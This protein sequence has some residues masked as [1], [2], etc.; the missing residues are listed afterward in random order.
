MDS[1]QVV[2]FGTSTGSC[3]LPPIALSR[4][5]ADE[6][7]ELSQ[8][9]AQAE[10]GIVV[11][12]VEMPDQ[13]FT[14]SFSGLYALVGLAEYYRTENQTEQANSVLNAV[15]QNIDALARPSLKVI[16]LAGVVGVF[17]SLNE[18]DRAQEVLAQATGFAEAAENTDQR[19]ISA[20]ALVQ[21]YSALGDYAAAS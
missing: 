20:M 21:A 12:G 17:A 2:W 11:P 18:N 14:R 13:S 7:S 3:P 10:G 15:L 8:E 4:Q 19:N 16:V 1:S 9:P 5:A 6:F